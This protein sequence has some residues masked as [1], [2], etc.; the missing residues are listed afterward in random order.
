LFVVSCV[1]LDVVIGK[2]A[3]IKWQLKLIVVVVDTILNIVLSSHIKES[4]TF[5]IQWYGKIM[6]ASKKELI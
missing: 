6:R 4:L 2:I 1:I 3:S 5:Q